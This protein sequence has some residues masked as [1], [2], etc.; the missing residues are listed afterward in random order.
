MTFL[1]Y[2]VI[3]AD[4]KARV[5][6]ELYVVFVPIDIDSIE[7]YFDIVWI[8]IDLGIFAVGFAALHNCLVQS[9][10]D[11]GCVNIGITPTEIGSVSPYIGIL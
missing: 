9:R 1:F 5:I 6:L 2:Y 10:G 8:A 3:L 11:F 4:I 7:P